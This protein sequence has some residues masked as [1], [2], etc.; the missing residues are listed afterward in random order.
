[1]DYK[2]LIE[3]LLY[4]STKTRPNIAFTVNQTVRFSENS[5]KGDLNTGIHFLK[6]IIKV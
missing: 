5:T 6:Y 3:S 4:A 2:R 1:M